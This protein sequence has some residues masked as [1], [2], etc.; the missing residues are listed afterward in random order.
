MD[1]LILAQ[2]GR[3]PKKSENVLKSK[4]LY[5]S[6]DLNLFPQKTL[7]VFFLMEATCILC[8]VNTNTSYKFK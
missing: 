8:E 5:I 4:Q 6:I 7:T 1:I 3:I 2:G